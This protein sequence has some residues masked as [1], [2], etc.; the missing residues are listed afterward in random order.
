MY[1]RPLPVQSTIHANRNVELNN[2]PVVISQSTIPSYNQP[3]QVVES[4]A[5][6][7]PRPVPLEVSNISKILENIQGSPV[8]EN[9]GESVTTSYPSG[10]T[11]LATFSKVAESEVKNVAAVTSNQNATVKASETVA[12]SDYTNKN[13]TSKGLTNNYGLSTPQNF[14]VGISKKIEP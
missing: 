9:K 6:N 10:T 8:V 1:Q 4:F 3:I 2:T 7:Q 5:V 13:D 14:D 11:N 12:W